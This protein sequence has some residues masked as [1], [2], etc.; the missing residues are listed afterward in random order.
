MKCLTFS[1]KKNMQNLIVQFQGLQAG[2]QLTL[3]IRLAGILT[4]TS[5]HLRFS[6]PGVSEGES[7][8]YCPAVQSSPERFALQAQTDKRKQKLFDLQNDL[9]H[10][11]PLHQ[12]VILENDANTRGQYLSAL[13]DAVDALVEASLS[14]I[15][16]GL[17]KPDVFL[18]ES[19]KSTHR[20]A[21]T[22]LHT[23]AFGSENQGTST[24]VFGG[25]RNRRGSHPSA[26]QGLIGIIGLL[27]DVAVE[28]NLLSYKTL[29]L[30]MSFSF[31]SLVF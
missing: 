29:A 17:V 10:L 7:A 3:I 6:S 27:I 9:R 2:D 23:I 16:S 13:R 8:L 21:G 15:V 28:P 11:F 18:G 19:L 5:Q 20:G 4:L 25:N 31:R 24:T 12:R 26:Q 30:R 1:N 14:L 22:L